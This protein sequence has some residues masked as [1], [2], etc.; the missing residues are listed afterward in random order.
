[1]KQGPASEGSFVELAHSGEEP[2]DAQ[3]L[4]DQ[5]YRKLKE[6]ILLNRLRPGQKL[7]V[8]ELA[9][10]LDVSR[11]PVRESLERLHQEG[12]T[13]RFSQ[14]GFYVAEIGT[15]DARDLYQ[16]REGLELFAL[17]LTMREPVAA[18]HIEELRA[19]AKTYTEIA[20]DNFQRSIADRK[21]HMY[22]AQLSGNQYIVQLLDEIFERTNWKR[23]TESYIP[24]AR[25]TVAEKEHSQLIQHLAEGNERMACRTLEKHIRNAWQA[26]E[27]HLRALE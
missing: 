22:L 9:K 4:N 27:R 20:Y 3:S 6:L 16:A 2:A 18:E 19:L 1:M 7:G 13:R 17:G 8:E 12:L 15:G 11:T 24:S 23:R 26:F 21:F 5:V 25:S 10:Q 14:R